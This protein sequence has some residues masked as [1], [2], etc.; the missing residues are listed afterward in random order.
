MGAMA[1]LRMALKRSREEEQKKINALIAAKEEPTKPKKKKQKKLKKPKK[2]AKSTK[3]TKATKATKA[4]KPKATKPKATKPKGV[5]VKADKTKKKSLDDKIR[6]AVLKIVAKVDL[7]KITMK[8][9]RPLIE[10]EVGVCLK[11]KRKM[12]KREVLA[13]LQ[14]ATTGGGTKEAGQSTYIFSAELSKFLN[15]EELKRTQ[16]VKR[17]WQHI[18]ENNLQNPDKKTEILNDEVFEEIFKCKKMGMFQM[19]KLL[20][21]HIKRRDECVGGAA[22]SASKSKKKAAK[23]PKKNPTATAPSKSQ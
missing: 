1:S 17:L 18:R 2:P 12:V 20:S 10:K 8:A 16:I 14:S 19:N 6:A 23:K 4:T 13:A 22:Q 3:V 5:K 7:E 21:Q 11:E 9:I 15:G